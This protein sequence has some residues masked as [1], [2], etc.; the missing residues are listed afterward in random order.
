L[1]RRLFDERGE[2]IES[3]STATRGESRSAGS[4]MLGVLGAAEIESESLAAIDS[5]AEIDSPSPAAAE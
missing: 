2:S 5:P 3:G 1:R 4:D